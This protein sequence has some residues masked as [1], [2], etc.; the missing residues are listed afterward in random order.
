MEEQRGYLA[1]FLKLID[2]EVVCSVLVLFF[3]WGLVRRKM[4]LFA[5][6]T[7]YSDE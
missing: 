6:R 1:I 7:R 5:P 4:L 3:Q 2:L